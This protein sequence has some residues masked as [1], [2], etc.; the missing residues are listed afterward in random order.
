MK[1]I[2]FTALLAL[3]SAATASGIVATL[4][5]RDG[6]E[7]L[8]TDAPCP[9]DR[10]SRV[11]MATSEGGH[12][13]SIGC[14]GTLPPDRIL[15]NWNSGTASLFKASNFTLIGAYPFGA[16]GSRP[17]ATGGKTTRGHFAKFKR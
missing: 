10:S 2:I 16:E 5:N 6:G 3:S 11:A 17:A 12:V 13:G 9:N 15:I 8:I 1:G 14:A 7:I 4:P